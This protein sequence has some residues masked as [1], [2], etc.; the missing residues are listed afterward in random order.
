MA[1][2]R[3]TRDLV[4]IVI[5]DI[6]RRTR[7]NGR[8]QINK[9]LAS[10]GLPRPRGRPP[11][12]RISKLLVDQHDVTIPLAPLPDTSSST[13][14]AAPPEATTPDTPPVRKDPPSLVKGSIARRRTELPEISADI[15]KTSD[16]VSNQ[17][18]DKGKAVLPANKHSTG[19]SPSKIDQ[20]HQHPN[21]TSDSSTETAVPSVSPH[22]T[23]R[24]SKQLLT[25]DS[26]IHDSR[27]KVRTAGKVLSLSYGYSMEEWLRT[28]DQH[29]H[30]CNPKTDLQDINSGYQY[31]LSIDE[32]KSRE[33]LISRDLELAEDYHTFLDRVRHNQV[34]M[35]P[36]DQCVSLEKVYF[37][38]NQFDLP[39]CDIDD[40]FANIVSGG[41]VY[42]F[43]CYHTG[44]SSISCIS[45]CYHAGSSSISSISSCAS[46]EA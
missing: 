2:Y 17:L 30:T 11:K 28:I 39:L 46:S 37:Q 24:Q 29:I 40:L 9:D 27:Y 23:Q 22:S 6:I 4:I 31:R 18:K 19:V 15:V 34:V 33:V 5:Q 14:C 1:K 13:P 45:C 12:N 25:A 20:Y 35:D 36:H 38:Q 7:E 43:C 26:S 32:N 41:D 42:A 3:W 10:R 21:S 16:A 8:R 44:S